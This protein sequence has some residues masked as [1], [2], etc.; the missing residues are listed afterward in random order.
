MSLKNPFTILRFGL[1][2]VF[3]ANA[4]SAWFSSQEFRDLLD[5]SFL[6]SHLPVIP[7]SA[8]LVLTGINDSL[9]TLILLFN[10]KIVMRFALI[11]AAIWLILVMIILWEPLAI[12]EHAG[13]LAMAIALLLNFRQNPQPAG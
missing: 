2:L 7:V 1:G 13:F 6:I 10:L 11:W 12:L 5:N 8:W 4:W 9:L 3:L